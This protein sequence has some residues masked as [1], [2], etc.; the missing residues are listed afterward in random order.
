MFFPKQSWIAFFHALMVASAPFST[1]IG[2]VLFGML[3]APPV[4]QKP[5]ETL[6]ELLPAA[7]TKLT[8]GKYEEAIA[9]Y[10]KT[11]AQSPKTSIVLVSA[12]WG[13]GAARLNQF[14]IANSRVRSLRIKSQSDKSLTDEY[15]A[16]QAKAKALFDRGVA[17]HLKAAEVADSIGLTE[18]GQQIREILPRLERG[19]IRYNNPY[20]SYLNRKL[21]RC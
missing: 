16:A 17:D 8:F 13:R 5:P 12:Y 14:T 3:T 15:Q 11:I 2:L 19:M 18:C 7:E 6:A 21:T 10:D 4:K 1:V 9:L 20:S